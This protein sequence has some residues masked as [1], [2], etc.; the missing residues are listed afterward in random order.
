[1]LQHLDE[2]CMSQMSNTAQGLSERLLSENRSG[3]S[4][5]TI[6]REDFGDQVNFATLNRIA[7]EGG[8]WLPK[9]RKV[10]RVLGLIEPKKRTAIQKAISRMA[11]DT[12]KA[13]LVQK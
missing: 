8:Q 9:D 5:R 11:R 1:M 4:W 3:R 7:R 13:V 10:L 2:N 12:K 6:A